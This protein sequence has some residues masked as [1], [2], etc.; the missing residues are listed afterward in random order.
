MAFVRLFSGGFTSTQQER[1]SS[2]RPAS[3]R[4]CFDASLLRSV[5]VTLGLF[6]IKFLAFSRDHPA[7]EDCGQ[8]LCHCVIAVRTTLRASPVSKS[9]QRVRFLRAARAAASSWTR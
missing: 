3:K 2:P 5:T 7:V 9:P 6:V 8:S 4:V 1:S